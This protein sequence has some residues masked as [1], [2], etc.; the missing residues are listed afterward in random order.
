MDSLEG[1]SVR[2]PMKWQ[3]ET[4]VWKGLVLKPLMNRND[5]VILHGLNNL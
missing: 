4:F 3:Y 2:S 5:P 1:K